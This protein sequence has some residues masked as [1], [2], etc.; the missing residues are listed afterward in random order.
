MVVH[1]CVGVKPVEHIFMWHQLYNHTKSSHMH[2]HHKPTCK[3]EQT[4][5]K[6][7]KCNKACTPALA[8][9]HPQNTSKGLTHT[10]LY[11]HPSTHA[12][13]LAPSKLQARVQ[14]ARKVPEGKWGKSIVQGKWQ[15]Q[16]RWALQPMP[17]SLRAMNC[18]S[19]RKT[20]STTQRFCGTSQ[21][22][23]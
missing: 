11:T 21:T 18:S 2:M 10:H 19:N 5:W 15:K 6:H 12:C 16:R 7:S 23:H 8:H 14:G 13:T 17:E 3:P 22:W 9:L 4:L 1:V 20:S